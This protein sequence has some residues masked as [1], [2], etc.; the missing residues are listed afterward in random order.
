MKVNQSPCVHM[1]S[2]WMDDSGNEYRI[3]RNDDET[4]S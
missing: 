2:E 1:R 3:E 4:L